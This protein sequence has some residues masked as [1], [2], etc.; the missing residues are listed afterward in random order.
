MFDEFDRVP[1]VIVERRSFLSVA[2]AAICA[3][4]QG[5]RAVG[6][7]APTAEPRLTLPEFL[8]AVV[9]VARELVADTTRMGEDRYLHTLASFAVR[10]VDVPVPEMRRITKGDGPHNFIGANETDD[11]C[12]FVVLHWRMEPRARVSLHPHTYGNVVTLGLEGEALIQNY[13]VDGVADYERATPFT[14]RKTHEQ[15]LRPG[16]INL[17]PLAH[18]YVHGFVAGPKGARGLDITTRIR[19]KQPNVALEVAATPIDAARG[20]YEGTW[21]FEGKK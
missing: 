13:E 19:D 21:R 5:R 1:G 11:D 16:E 8:K 7:L 14:V 6:P 15:I 3:T 4:T 9:P 17:V 10:L 18:G 12:P 20:L 2:A